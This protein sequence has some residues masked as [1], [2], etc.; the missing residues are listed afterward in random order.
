MKFFISGI[1]G[2]LGGNIAHYIP[3][4]YE[5][6]PIELVGVYAHNKIVKDDVEIIKADITDKH[7]LEKLLD[8]IRPDIIFHCAAITN[9]DY[10]EENPSAAYEVHVEGTKNLALSA[11]KTGAKLVYISTDAVFDGEKGNYSEEDEPNPINIYAKTK[12]EGETV[13]KDSLDDYLIFRTNFY[14]WNIREKYSFSEWIL[15][16]LLEKKQLT[17]FTDVFFT[18]IFVNDLIEVMVELIKNDARGLYHIGGDERCSKYHFGMKLAEIFNLDQHYIQPIS[19]DQFN[20]KAKRSKDMS[21]STKKL[22]DMLNNRLL[23]T[24]EEGIKKFKDCL[25][26]GY[27]DKLKH[28]EYASRITSRLGG[29]V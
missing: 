10:C 1:S 4:L 7:G 25:T 29:T 2:L 12:L 18:P 6:E 16:D 5:E 24:I 21:L 13:V 19:V 27:L 11:G 9:I 8:K 17:M 26:N 15:H 14:G 20:F 22:S 3:Y 23:P 28:Q